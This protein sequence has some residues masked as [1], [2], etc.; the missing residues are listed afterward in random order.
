M[1]DNRNE[2]LTKM[3]LQWLHDLREAAP[4]LLSEQYSNPYY[5]GIPEE[6]FDT[7]RPRILIVGEEGF[8][9][10]GCGKAGVLNDSD[11]PFYSAEDIQPIQSFTTNYLRTQLGLQSTSAYNKSPFWNRVRRVA[12]YGVCCWTNIDKIHRLSNKRCALHKKERILLH[13]TLTRIL[14]EEIAVLQPTHIVFFGWYGISL[15]H[16]LPQLFE[17]LYPN[18]LKDDSVW[19]E[20]KIVSIDTEQYKTLFLYHPSWGYRNKGYERTVD[21]ALKSMFAQK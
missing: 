12:K 1:S 15:Q 19:K 4:L 13:T 6:W 7:D 5:V 10:W 18:G 8:G 17:K 3:Y 14:L 20:K 11:N 21:E 2:H 16:E 9:S